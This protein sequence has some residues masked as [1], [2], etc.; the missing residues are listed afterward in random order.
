MHPCIE[1]ILTRHAVRR[2]QERQVEEDTLQEILTA[3]LYAPS[4]GNNQHSRIV[5]CQ[6][7]EINQKLG[8]INRYMMFKGKDPAKVYYAITAD[9][10]SIQDDH[11]ILDVFYHA[12][13]VLHLFVR[14]SIY[15]HDDAAMMAENMWLAAHALGVG[16]CY[17]GR[18]EEVFATD[19]GKELREKWGVPADLVAVAHLC[20]GYRDGPAPHAKPRK[21]GRILRA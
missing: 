21:E 1:T 17:I 18:A 7:R 12:H 15:A 13:T 6:D 5:V 3:G 4:A 11:T 20:L 14:D 16:A 2:F 19:F 9:Q 10:P 8:E